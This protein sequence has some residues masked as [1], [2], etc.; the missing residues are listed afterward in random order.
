[1]PPSPLVR[2]CNFESFQCPV[3]DIFG[4]TLSAQNLARHQ[5]TLGPY[6][7][8]DTKVPFIERYIS[9]QS[10]LVQR[11]MDKKEKSESIG[12][13]GDEL[14]YVST[15]ARCHH[16]TPAVKKEGPSRV[17]RLQA[18]D[19]STPNSS[20]NKAKVSGKKKRFALDS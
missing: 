18:R 6:H 5:Q 7:Y 20:K 14:G 2:V 10:S 11:E 15:T 12:V 4:Q 17:E 1:M 13:P 3:P 9:E 19:G 16:R 8:Y